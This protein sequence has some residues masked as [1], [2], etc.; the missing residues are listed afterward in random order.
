MA[1]LP[2]LDATVQTYPDIERWELLHRLRF[3]TDHAVHLRQVSNSRLRRQ[4]QLHDCRTQWTR[5][6]YA[7]PLSQV[8]NIGIRR[9]P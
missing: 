9:Q 8:L 5:T 2:N 4:T 7:V 1:P 3:R 6:E